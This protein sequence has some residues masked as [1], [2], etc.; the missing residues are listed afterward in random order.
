MSFFANVGGCGPTTPKASLAET[1]ES[2]RNKQDSPLSWTWSALDRDTQPGQIAKE[3]VPRKRSG[4]GC[5]SGVTEVGSGPE[6]MIYVSQAAAV[7]LPRQIGAAR[8]QVRTDATRGGSLDGDGPKP[9]DI[10]REIPCSMKA[11]HPEGSLSV[12]RPALSG[13]ELPGRTWNVGRVDF[14]QL[15]PAGVPCLGA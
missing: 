13:D 1:F 9:G 14:L 2:V 15:S 3:F 6:S 10:A 7:H 8:L 4:P 5:G 11:S 12:P